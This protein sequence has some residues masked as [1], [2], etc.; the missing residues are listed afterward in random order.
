MLN[1]TNGRVT[2]LVR[3]LKSVAIEQLSDF[4][5]EL[6]TFVHKVDAPARV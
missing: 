3:D 6:G 4:V 2:A 5:I 1:L